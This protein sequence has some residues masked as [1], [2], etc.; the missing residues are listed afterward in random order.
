M[1]PVNLETYGYLPKINTTISASFIEDF[2]N[3]TS[4]WANLRKNKDMLSIEEREYELSTKKSYSILFQETINNGL[5]TMIFVIDRQSV[6]E[7]LT[8]DLYNKIVLEIGNNTSNIVNNTVTIGY[9]ENSY[10]YWRI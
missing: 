3:A 9:V 10:S 5:V 7:K 8:L 2:S 6:T 4:S 1:E